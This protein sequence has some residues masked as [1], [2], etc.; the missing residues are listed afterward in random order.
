MDA[1]AAAMRIACVGGGPG[2]LTLAALA[3][4]RA[5]DVTLFE[6]RASGTY[7]LGV[8]LWPDHL[9]DL[10]LLDPLLVHRLLQH[11]VAWRDQHIST[12]GSP[13]VVLEGRGHGIARATMLSLLE[14]RAVELGARV[15]RGTAIEH[16]DVLGSFDAV[17]LAD[18]AASALRSMRAHDFGSRTREE[19]NR[20]AWLELD[21]P[22][23]RFAFPFITAGDG[24]AWA[25]AYPFRA[26]A[27]TFIVETTESAWIAEGFDHMPTDDAVRRLEALFADHLRGGSLRPARGTAPDALWSRFRLVE[28]RRWSSGRTAL[29]GDAAHT[30]HFSIGSGTRLAM[31]DAATLVELLDHAPS[32]EEALRTYD[33]RRRDEL[34]GIQRSARLSARFL[35]RLPRYI[36]RPAE[37][38]AHLLE[39]RRSRLL[40]LIP[41]GIYLGLTR[42]RSGR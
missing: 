11:A 22:S 37:D 23:D 19:G 30:T 9:S 16:P 31:E 41:T 40:P 7:G 4:G 6:Q 24:W 25:H 15:E 14:Q 3:A 29:L 38:F 10:A 20:Y 33:T 35:G 1:H 39:R 2:G 36:D 26:G 21:R 27:T 17:I 32:A 18:G 28:N 12:P 8:V 34:R 5:H 42:P 13:A